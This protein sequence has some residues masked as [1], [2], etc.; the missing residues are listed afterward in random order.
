MIISR[1]SAM[2]GLA[3][4]RDLDVTPEQIAAWENGGLA[5]HVF[6]H[7]SPGEREFIISGTTP[8]EWAQYEALMDEFEEK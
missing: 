6:A 7:L 4:E 5:Q 1:I 2:S 3:H 8:E